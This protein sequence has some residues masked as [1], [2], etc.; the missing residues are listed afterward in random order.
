M[1]KLLHFV[2]LAW[3]VSPAH[4]L[5]LFVQ[6]LE[7]AAK[8]LLNVILP[9][10]L[11][12]ELTGDR[13]LERLILFAGLIVLNNVGMTLLDNLLNRF[14]S[15]LQQKTSQGMLKLMSEKVMNLEYSYLE[16][17]T[18]LDL[19]ERAVFTI[20]NQNAI[21]NTINAIFQTL[22]Q[23]LTMTGMITILA[24]LGPVLIIV[25]VVGG[26]EILQ[27]AVSI[28]MGLHL[29]GMEMIHK[30]QVGNLIINMHLLVRRE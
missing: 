16:N 17:P 22:T 14:C 6:S 29:G 27:S 9:M 11:V 7:N 24:T 30:V 8:T 15:V 12:N 26:M 19:K 25:L 21:S 3:S 1:K 5:L 23:A 18:Y 20:Q 4:I 2:K 10:F 28:Q 13:I